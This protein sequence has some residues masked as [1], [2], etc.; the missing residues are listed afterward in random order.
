MPE[1]YAVRL[2]RTDRKILAEL[3]QDCRIPT[4]VLARKV[5]KSR[6]AVEYRINRLVER[7]IITSF[8]AAFNPH[9]MGHKIYKIYLKLR[10]IPDEKQRLFAWLK[11]SGIVYWMGECSG[12]WDLIFGVF[13]KDDYAFYNLKNSLT[14]EFSTIIVEEHGDILVDVKQYP[15]MYFTGEILE[16]TMFAGEVVENELDKLDYAVLGEVVNNARISVVELAK[17]V[18]STQTIVRGRLRHLEQRGIIIQYRIGVDLNKLGLELYKAVI[19]LDRY[20]KEDESRLLEYC[21]RLPNIHYF[22]RNLWQIEPELVVENYQEYYR[23]VEELKR[24]F[25]EVIRTVDSVL[26]ITDEWTPGFRNLLRLE[27]EKKNV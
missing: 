5:L 18:H 13:S 16:P 6:Q 15:K 12:S 21:S 3:D 7:G 22:I 2:D 8:N 14:N 23:I 25:P 24:N 4:T 11:A 1:I 26:M 17:K 27:K 20:T 9:K 10:N 19:K